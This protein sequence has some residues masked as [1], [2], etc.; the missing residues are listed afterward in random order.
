[1]LAVCLYYKEKLILGSHTLFLQKFDARQLFRPFRNSSRCGPAGAARGRLGT[2]DWRCGARAG[3]TG[4]PCAS[5]ARDHEKMRTR[6]VDFNEKFYGQEKLILGRTGD[7]CAS[8]ALAARGREGW[9]A[10]SEV[11]RK[12]MQGV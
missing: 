5:A 3:R 8:T 6:E 11:G 9:A 10:R 4:D 12:R 7:P 1:M 2:A